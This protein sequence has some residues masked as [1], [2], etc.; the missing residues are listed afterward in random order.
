M[1]PGMQQLHV[2]FAPP[3]SM[4]GGGDGEVQAVASANDNVRNLQAIAYP[5]AQ[6]GGWRVSL[7]FERIDK[8]RPVELRLFLRRGAQTLSETWTYALSPE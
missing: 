7:D 4:A 1:P 6:R 3:A 5:N 2:D 8:A